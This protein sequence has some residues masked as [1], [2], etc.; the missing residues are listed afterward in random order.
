[1]THEYFFFL[2]LQKVDKPK[3][4]DV[5][6]KDLDENGDQVVDFIEYIILFAA[7]TLIYK[8]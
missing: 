8:K 4:L 6:M 5:L 3:D 7:V 2:R 1:M